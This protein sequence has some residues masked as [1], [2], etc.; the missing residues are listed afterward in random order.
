MSYYVIQDSQHSSASIFL[1]RCY[2]TSKRKWTYFLD[3]AREF[4]NKLEA[5]FFVKHQKYNHPKVVTKE[6]AELIDEINQIKFSDLYTTLTTKN[7]TNTL[8]A[9]SEGS[10]D[11]RTSRY[12]INS[13]DDESYFV[14][15]SLSKKLGTLSCRGSYACGQYVRLD[16]PQGEFSYVG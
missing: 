12:Y 14:Q 6:E 7:Q 10:T 13:I 2:K 1:D 9:V 11:Y 8:K 4:R 16:Y 3:F 5:E 15:I